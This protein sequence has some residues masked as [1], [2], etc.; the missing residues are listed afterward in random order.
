MNVAGLE[1]KR[2]ELLTNCYGSSILHGVGL[3][4]AMYVIWHI[5][6]DLIKN[7]R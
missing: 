3:S 2:K 6:Q 4:I 7:Q 5:A 1:K